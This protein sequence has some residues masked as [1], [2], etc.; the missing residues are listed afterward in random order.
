MLPQVNARALEV[1]DGGTSVDYD[2]AGG[3]GAAMWAGDV[4]AYYTDAAR[5][6]TDGTALNRVS[7]D[8][9]IIDTISPAPVVG[10][11]VRFSFEGV[12]QTREIVAVG[13]RPPIPGIPATH[14]LYLRTR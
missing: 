2:Y 12:E 7:S 1:N 8:V 9:L 3:G 14:K 5:I 10:N 4:D 11:H 13:K 6:E